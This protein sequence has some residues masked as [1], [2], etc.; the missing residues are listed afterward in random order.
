[1]Y[2]PTC[3]CGRSGQYQIRHVLSL[4]P[5]GEHKQMVTQMNAAVLF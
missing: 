2:M 5:A 1:M 3:A 4:L